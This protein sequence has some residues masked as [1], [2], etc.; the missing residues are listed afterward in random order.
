MTNCA[1]SVSIIIPGVAQAGCQLV[2]HL[3]YN[4]IG[5]RVLLTTN[6]KQNTPK[7][8]KLVTYKT[9]LTLL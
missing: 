4:P 3:N 1:C 2:K 8:T 9:P 7:T 6:L 5:S